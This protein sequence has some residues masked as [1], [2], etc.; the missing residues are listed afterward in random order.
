M[1]QIINDV[2]NSYGSTSS[3]NRS[4][5]DKRYKEN[6][7]SNLIN[8]L[9]AIGIVQ[10]TTDLNDDVS[11]VVS[12]DFDRD[13]GCRGIGL[14]LSLVGGYACINDLDCMFMCVQ[15]RVDS[16]LSAVLG[17]LA[18]NNVAVLRREDLTQQIAFD[19]GAA[20]IYKVLFS[21]DEAIFC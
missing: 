9:I 13:C 10:E 8:E 5:V 3:P 6:T 2:I 4:F 1:N 11:V 18:R 14:K 19:G 7:Y 21:D 15:R 12:M 16:C 20:T 17:I